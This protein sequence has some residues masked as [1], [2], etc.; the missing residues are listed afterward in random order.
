ML[1]Q[2]VSILSLASVGLAVTILLGVGLARAARADETAPDWGAIQKQMD[3]MRAR[4]DVLEEENAKLREQV[5]G[6][7]GRLASTPPGAQSAQLPPVSANSPVGYSGFNKGGGGAYIKGEEYNVRLLGYAQVVGSVF[8]SRFDRP[9]ENGDFSIRRARIDFAADF[10][11]DYSIFVE[12]DGGPA[13]AQTGQSDFGLVE[14]RIN[15]KIVEDDVQLRAGKFISPFSAENF[16]SSRD[17][18]TVERYMALNSIFALPALD[19]QF[20]AMVH[21][22]LGG[23]R[24]V[25][26]Y[27]G[28]F[29]GSG[30]A[31]DNFSDNNGGKEL[32]SKVT[33]AQPGF[34][35][36]LA[37]D[38]ANDESEIISLTDLAFNNFVSIPVDGTRVGL[39]GDFLM[40]RGPWSLRGEGLS[41]RFDGDESPPAGMPVQRGKVWITGGF[42]QPAVFL[43]GDKNKGLQLLMRGELARLEAD[44]GPNGDKLYALTL[45]ANWFVNPNVRLQVNGILQYFD[46]PSALQ[47]FADDEVVPLLLT[48]LQFKF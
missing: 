10:Y 35:A 14:A 40:E 21:G 48:E 4:Q 2:L 39:G 37:F 1:S 25:G 15:W 30:R 17:I 13:N 47:P 24:N 38:L 3:A 19:A 45:A 44:T 7:Q 33:Y 28:L 23:D 36:G 29:N 46:G 32:V 8:D 31:N 16:R 9:D 34:S 5:G 41:F 18:D 43:R 26:Y 27:V 20:G 11:D 42:I 6:L 12:F 22:V